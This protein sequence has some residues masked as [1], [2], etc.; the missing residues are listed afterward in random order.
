MEEVG[1]EA[2]VIAVLD[3]TN[4]NSTMSSIKD[5]EEQD[6]DE[7]DD[8]DNDSNE[9]SSPDALHSNIGDDGQKN[10]SVISPS[11]LISQ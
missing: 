3:T 4:Q 10:D 11:R 7:S 1:E 2:N 5:I 6:W 8:N 9:D